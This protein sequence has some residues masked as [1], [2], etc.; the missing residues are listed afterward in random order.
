MSI[1]R[2]PIICAAI[3]AT[4]AS[5][6]ATP[7]PF[8]PQESAGANSLSL[9]GHQ[10][11]VMDR[12]TNVGT[13]VTFACPSGVNSLVQVLG[14]VPM[15]STL[16]VIGWVSPQTW[17]V[18]STESPSPTYNVDMCASVDAGTRGAV[19]AVS[20]DGGRSWSAG[21]RP[22]VDASPRRFGVTPDGTLIAGSAA[23]IWWRLVGGAWVTA[24]APTLP[25]M[26]WLYPPAG[27]DDGDPFYEECLLATPCPARPQSIDDFG[28][29]DARTLFPGLSDPRMFGAVWNGPGNGV[30][31]ETFLLPSR[32]VDTEYA[33]RIGRINAAGGM[34]FFRPSIKYGIPHRICQRRSTLYPEIRSV[35]GGSL[36]HP[37]T[38][39]AVTA[40]HQWVDCSRHGGY[41][42]RMVGAPRND[43]AYFFRQR[44]LRSTDYGRT[45][46]LAFN[47][48]LYGPVAAGDAIYGSLDG[49][50]DRAGLTLVKVVN[51]RIAADLGAPNMVNMSNASQPAGPLFALG[52]TRPLP[53][54]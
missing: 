36:T 23:G 11:S 54:R 41:R 1:R 31:Q 43:H 51:R 49:Y 28:R 24:A 2:L 9:M 10:V 45:W 50:K 15:R 21:P 13:T 18:T 12:Q 26:T 34:T 27:S 52:K 42:T 4:C 29:P 17:T 44:L 35:V 5:A 39:L 53:R 32:S 37:G 48:A 33:R 38:Y 47:Q 14:V 3:L 7:Y 30:T 40:Q 8:V 6:A 46:T 16:G 20:A 22:P 25:A 19:M